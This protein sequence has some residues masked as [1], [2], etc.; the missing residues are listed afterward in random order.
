[1]HRRF[2]RALAGCCCVLSASL[3]AQSASRVSDI[4]Y[5]LRFD[6]TLARERLVGVA[7]TFTAAGTDPVLLSFP[8]WT[9]GSYEIGNFARNVRD[10]TATTGGGGGGGG[11]GGTP[12]RWDKA[13]PDTWRLWTG[14]SG[15]GEVR[16]EFRFLADSLDNGMAWARADFLLVNGTNVFPYPEGIGLDFP[17]T[18]TVRTEPGWRVATGMRP[19]GSG[20]AAGTASAPAPNTY[21]EA[22]YHDLVDMPFFV[23]RFDYDSMA[24]EGKTHRLAS[25]P[26]GTLQGQARAGFWEEIGKMVPPMSAVFQETPWESYT[27]LLIFDST[28]GGGSA[29]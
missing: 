9:P 12:L 14:G 22:N 10:F 7:M 19:A 20:R 21:R 13:D 4:R 24:I 6:A 5:E 1:M 17:A 26:A 16:V 11:G 27:T 23:G 2:L 29:L 18:V 8:A 25:Y 3:P 15:P 28:S